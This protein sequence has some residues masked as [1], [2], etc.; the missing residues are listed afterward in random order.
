M[1]RVF[2]AYMLAF[3]ATAHA[4]SLWD[5]TYQDVAEMENNAG[6]KTILTNGQ[7]PV[8]SYPM[9]AYRIVDNKGA[10]AGIGCWMSAGNRIKYSSED[11]GAGEWD[12]RDFTP[13][14]RK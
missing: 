8:C 1:K 9:Y 14:N 4:A 11:F 12:A 5:R 3:A 2:L 13:V 7:S 6:W 10:L